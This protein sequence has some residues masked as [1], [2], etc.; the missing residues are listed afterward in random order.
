M[1]GEAYNVWAGNACTNREAL[2]QVLKVLGAPIDLVVPVEDRQ[3]HDRYYY[4]DGE[5]LRAL[6]WK[7]EYHLESALEATVEWYRDNR[8]WW[9]PIKSGEYQAYYEKQYGERLAAARD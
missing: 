7:P 8:W 9:E 3:G 1:P 6:G 4:M 5:K 2:D